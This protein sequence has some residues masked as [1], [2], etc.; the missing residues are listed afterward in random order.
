MVLP[1]QGSDPSHNCKLSRNC[2]NVGSLTHCSWLGMEPLSQCSQEA[3][4]P[5]ASQWE[6]QADIT[7]CA[8]VSSSSAEAILISLE[9]QHCFR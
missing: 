2:G 7:A 9:D 4:D 6:L 5:I 3:A 1:G 8:P